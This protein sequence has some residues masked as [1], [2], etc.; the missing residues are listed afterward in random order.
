MDTRPA[1]AQDAV[2]QTVALIKAQMPETYRSVQAKSHLVGKV[3]FALVRRSL[4]GEANCFWACE[5]GHVVGTP[6]A[7]NEI[8]RDIAQLMVQFGSTY[9]CIWGKDAAKAAAEATDGAH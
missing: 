8:T 7:D 9:V 1:A 6:F 4:K 3:A 2:E 5:R